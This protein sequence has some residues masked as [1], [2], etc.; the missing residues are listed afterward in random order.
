MKKGVK[1]DGQ[2]GATHAESS[3]DMKLPGI[4]S[5]TAISF[6]G[7]A[8]SLVGTGVHWM[9]EE[10]AIWK[11]AL[12]GGIAGMVVGSCWPTIR[13]FFRR[14]DLDDWRLEEVEIQ[15]FKFTSAG[16]QRRVAWKLFVEMATRISTQPMQEQDGDDA[17]ALKSL[18]DLFQLTRN[19]ISEMEPT[20]GAAGN[21]VET[22]ALEMLNAD[23]RPFLAKWHPLLDDFHHQPIAT[24]EP[25]PLH[26]AFRVELKVLQSR[27][28]E[29]A[30]GLGSLAG[31]SNVDR[32]F[33]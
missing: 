12:I 28:K 3:M 20:P 29:R 24:R 22:Y 6:A 15:G 18:H 31:V 26:G 32:F 21:T 11:A 13:A 9:E 27:I 33:K 2:E 16:A 1:W 4:K 25:R 8:G 23:L 14:L 30:R 19:A 7:M 17:A 5:I 10:H